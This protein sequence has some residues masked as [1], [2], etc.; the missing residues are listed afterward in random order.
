MVMY[1]IRTTY[2]DGNYPGVSK[3]SKVSHGV[4]R[5]SYDT[6]IGF[7]SG[8]ASNPP[9]EPSP[10]EMVAIAGF[11]FFGLLVLTAYTAS[12]AAA[13]VVSP[14]NAPVFGVN[15]LYTSSDDDS[16]LICLPELVRDAFLAIHID[17]NPDAVWGTNAGNSVL[18]NNYLS[19]DGNCSA[20]I[21]P[22]DASEL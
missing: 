3:W 22:E 12:S 15:N 21:L 4:V 11:A 5:A 7:T 20:L 1:I 18:I 6:I 10:G 16:Y 14:Q 8:A 9:D 17:V 13:M 19:D 2:T